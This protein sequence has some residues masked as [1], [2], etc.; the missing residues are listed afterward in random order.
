MYEHFSTNIEKVAVEYAWLGGDKRKIKVLKE[1]ELSLDIAVQNQTRAALLIGDHS[2]EG[3]EMSRPPALKIKGKIPQLQLNMT[4]DV[5][6]GLINLSKI[7]SQNNANENLKLLLAEK[8]SLIEES[9]FRADI[10]VK[11]INRRNG[12]F[13][14]FHVIMSGKF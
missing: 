9:S 10:K 7:L 4:P 5:Y 14:P 3:L 13:E 6:N 8:Q 2:S 11:G 1:I 12:F